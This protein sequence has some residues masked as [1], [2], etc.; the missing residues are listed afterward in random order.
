MVQSPRME[1]KWKFNIWLDVVQC[2][3]TMTINNYHV[4]M[5]Y[6]THLWFSSVWFIYSWTWNMSDVEPVP[7]HGLQFLLYTKHAWH[8]TNRLAIV[9]FPFAKL[10]IYWQGM[11]GEYGHNYMTEAIKQ[12]TEWLC[13]QYSKCALGWLT[14]KSALYSKWH[15]IAFHLIWSKRHQIPF[16]NMFC[17]IFWMTSNCFASK[18][19]SSNTVVVHSAKIHLWP[20]RAPYT[21]H[22]SGWRIVLFWFFPGWNQTHEVLWY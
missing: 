16:N 9:V 10:C 7:P 11:H 18:K 20:N 5:V 14:R 13:F 2:G 19:W 4:A 1:L 22:S 8:S 3:T 21:F 6:T 17:F 15:Q 12:G